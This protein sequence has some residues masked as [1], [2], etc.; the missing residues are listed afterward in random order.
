MHA[1]LGQGKQH[2]ADR[3][4]GLLEDPKIHGSKR[5]SGRTVA[6]SL[7]FLAINRPQG[8][9]PCTGIGEAGH[10]P[11]HGKPTRFDAVGFEH[12]L[13]KTQRRVDSPEVSVPGLIAR[14]NG[15]Q[16]VLTGGTSSQGEATLGVS[17][18]HR[19][20]GSPTTLGA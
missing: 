8:A 4:P 12:G 1:F 16:E 10:P 7:A 14:T 6:G 19:D 17:S 18:R 15:L 2:F 11:R 20:L 3:S 13:W 5:S 9:A